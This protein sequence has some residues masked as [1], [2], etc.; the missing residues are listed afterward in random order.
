[1]RKEKIII[2]DENEFFYDI[3]ELLSKYELTIDVKKMSEF[4]YVEKLENFANVIYDMLESGGL[5]A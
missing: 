4:E 2:R 3:V 5:I 1:M